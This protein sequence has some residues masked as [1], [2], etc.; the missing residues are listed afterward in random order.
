MR[1]STSGYTKTRRAYA[2]T[3]AARKSEHHGGRN[4]LLSIVQP[5]SARAGRDAGSAGA[6]SALPAGVHGT[7]A[8]RGKSDGSWTRLGAWPT[9]T[10]WQ[11]PPKTGAIKGPAIGLLVTGLL[12]LFFNLLGVAMFA[13]LV[14]GGQKAVDGLAS[15][16]PPGFMQDLIRE[17]YG[18][19]KNAFNLSFQIVFLVVSVLTVA[20]AV[21]MLRLRGFWLAVVG[22]VLAI[23]NF[24][25]LCCCLGAPFGIWS[26]VVLFQP[27]IRSAF[28]QR[29]GPV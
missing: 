18:P 17:N 22:S 16:Y 11:A 8:R 10:A 20:A 7:D 27:A 21:Q 25:S 3:L 15:A 26:L 14:V 28:E 12:G 4:A 29:S 13:Y 24:N 2:S 5:K 1:E 6:V 9:G 23:V 19:Q